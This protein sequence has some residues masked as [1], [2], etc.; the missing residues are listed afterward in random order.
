M[1][2]GRLFI[3]SVTLYTA[4]VTWHNEWPCFQSQPCQEAIN[5]HSE[6]DTLC[7][8]VYIYNNNQ[9]RPWPMTQKGTC[10]SPA[11]SLLHS[12]RSADPS[13]FEQ[14]SPWE[15]PS[16]NTKSR[17]TVRIALDFPQGRKESDCTCMR[18]ITTFHPLLCSVCNTWKIAAFFDI[19][20][21]DVLLLGKIYS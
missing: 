9:V 8:I 13:V 3:K 18:N 7:H 4:S 6:I 5:S 12:V 21:Q 10:P 19:V 17:S 15:R 20:E 11:A 2:S 16:L 14:P 1:I